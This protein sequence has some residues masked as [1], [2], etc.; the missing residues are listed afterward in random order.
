MIL[1]VTRDAACRVAPPRPDRPRRSDTAARPRGRGLGAAG[2]LVALGHRVTVAG[3]GGG[4]DGQA[5]RVRLGAAGGRPDSPAAVVE[6]VGRALGARKAGTG[7][8]EPGP[9]RAVAEWAAFRSTYREALAEA[10]A[11]ALCGDLPV[12]LPVGAYADLVREARSD[13][14]PTLLD[15]AGEPLRRAVA[16]RPDTIT[17]SPEALA[18]LTGSHE[19]VGAVG[20]ARRRGARSVV[21]RLGARGLI[22]GTPEG[23]WRVT[24]PA[25][26]P[27]DPADP[28]DAGEAV[29][30]GLLSGLV[31]GVSWPGRLARA[32]ALA[33]SGIAAA[34]DFDRAGYEET[35]A[36]VEITAEP[37]NQ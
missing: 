13:G 10:D 7:P 33:V 18:G 20:D 5:A 8:E 37:A 22:A 25:H 36:G 12:G 17:T 28:V 30:A 31:E 4:P 6:P 27:A 29:I 34:G 26:A 11:V 2:A 3:L 32:V 9:A 14:V 15:M 21:V 23:L 24:P 19:P 35:L 16:A 1:I